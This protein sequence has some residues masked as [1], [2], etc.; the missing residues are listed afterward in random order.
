VASGRYGNEQYRLL[1]GEVMDTLVRVDGPAH[2]ETTVVRTPS[3]TVVHL[4]SFLPSRQAEGMDLAHDPFP[5]V[6]IPVAGRV[7]RGADR[8]AAGRRRDQHCEGRT[9]ARVA[10]QA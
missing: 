8:V 6:N 2:L 10:R 1:L 5:M 3:S 9:A 4:L 7:S